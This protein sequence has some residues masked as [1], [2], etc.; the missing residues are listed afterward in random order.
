[1][2]N[3][4][5]GAVVV[6]L[7]AFSFIS[8]SSSISNNIT[9][10]N[11]TQGDLYI[12]FRGQ[13]VTVPAGQTSKVGKIPQG[14]YDYATTFSV[15]ASATSASSQG[16]LTGTFKVTADTKILLYYTSTLISGAYTVYVTISNSD[17]QSTG[18]TTGP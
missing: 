7:F 8:C 2:K 5:L 4:L 11:Q 17:N 13:I 1:M 18:T 12:N 14:T 6:F 16:N 9:F 3:W 10:N 15:P